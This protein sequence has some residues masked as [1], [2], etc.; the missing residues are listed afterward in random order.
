[1]SSRRRRTR[2]NLRNFNRFF[3]LE[4]RRKR[5]HENLMKCNDSFPSPVS[6]SKVEVHTC[7][8]KC[9][10]CSFLCQL[11]GF[12]LYWTNNVWKKTVS[13]CLS[14]NER[15]YWVHPRET[16][17]HSLITSCTS[18]HSLELTKTH[19]ATHHTQ[20]HTTH[21]HTPHTHT[22]TCICMPHNDR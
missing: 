13:L 21:S 18:T 3:K 20:S 4:R 10:V 5:R 16:D 12:C 7:T 22:D 17:R 8:C 6:L 19:T 15:C 9:M 11:Y 14:V 1:M 2:Y